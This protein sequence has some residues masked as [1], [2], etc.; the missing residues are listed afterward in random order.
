MKLDETA[1]LWSSDEREGKTLLVLLH[2]YG[3]SEDDLFG[4]APYLPSE[5]VL[6]AVRAPLAPPWPSPGFS[7]YPIEGLEGRDPEHVT[8]AAA[9]LIEWVDRQGFERVGLLGFSQGGAV[10]LQ[11][12]RLAP[13]RFAFAVNLSGYA[14]PGPSPRDA[15]L[16]EAS[17]PVF[18]GRGNRDDV[19]PEPLIAHTTEWLPRHSDL[20]G[21]VYSG[22]THSVSQ[23]ELDDVRAFL[24]KR[25][26]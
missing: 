10:S 18:W 23:D 3:S 19:I 17:I 22:L 26:D 9:A 24:Q 2:G 7:W 11:A 4:L 25:L 12:L 14:A 1:V 15:E 13:E 8:D 21:R 5:F 20:A 16:A 6:A